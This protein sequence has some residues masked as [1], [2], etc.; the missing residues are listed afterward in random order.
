MGITTDKIMEV[1][2]FEINMKIIKCS[3]GG[4][5]T[6]MSNNPKLTEKIVIFFDEKTGTLT[7]NLFQDM[8]SEKFKKIF[9]DMWNEYMDI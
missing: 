3:S 6:L 5:Y 1:L 9:S 4:I 7:S 8:I 2:A